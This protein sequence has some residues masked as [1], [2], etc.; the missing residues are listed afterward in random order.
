M[1]DAL[2][3]LYEAAGET[4][5]LDE[6]KELIETLIAHYQDAH[7]AFFNTADDQEKLLVRTADP[8]DK[9]VP[10]GN[11]AAAAALI[12]LAKITGDP[13]YLERAKKILNRFLG[14]MKQA[15]SHTASLLT[16]SDRL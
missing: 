16:A 1:A 4:R 8:Y 5:R 9:A 2:L 7:G 15:P 14:F 11:G 6:A 10:S 13:K 12:K 3:E